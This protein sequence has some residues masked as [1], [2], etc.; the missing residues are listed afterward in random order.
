MQFW[1]TYLLRKRD[2]AIADFARQDHALRAA[3]SDVDGHR[4]KYHIGGYSC[5]YCTENG[6]RT[7]GT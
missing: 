5:V 1:L 2:Q 4:L 6:Q 3:G 7:R